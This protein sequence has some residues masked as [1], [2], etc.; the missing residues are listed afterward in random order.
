MSSNEDSVLLV[1]FG[2]AA[3]QAADDSLLITHCLNLSD[4][5][6][7]ALKHSHIFFGLAP[8]DYATLAVQTG[9]KGHVMGETL[10]LWPSSDQLTTIDVAYHMKNLWSLESHPEF[11]PGFCQQLIEIG[12]HRCGN[13]QHGTTT[14]RFKVSAN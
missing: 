9:V 3:G 13:A 4:G 2:G 1:V 8:G 6:T 12:S 11:S 10:P 5:P 14:R 7:H